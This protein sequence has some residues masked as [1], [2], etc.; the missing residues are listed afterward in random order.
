MNLNLLMQSVQSVRSG[1]RFLHWFIYLI[2]PTSPS[3]GRLLEKKNCMLLWP[4]IEPWSYRVEVR[5][6]NHSATTFALSKR[7]LLIGVCK[8]ITIEALSSLILGT[9]KLLVNIVV[10]LKEDFGSFATFC[11]LFPGGSFS[12]PSHISE[13][14]EN[15]F[16]PTGNFMILLV[17][18]QISFLF[19]EILSTSVSATPYWLLDRQC[20]RL[21]YSADVLRTEDALTNE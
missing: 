6:F 12:R 8:N 7:N 13:G 18:V 1:L 9:L 2:R 15:H 19:K 21:K 4:G 10:F 16:E 17:V 5:I 3:L 20:F 14:N 11:C